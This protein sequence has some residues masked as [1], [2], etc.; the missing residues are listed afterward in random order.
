MELF[1]IVGAIIPSEMDVHK[2]KSEILAAL[3]M[4]K[5]NSLHP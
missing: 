2:R 5:A 4:T 3:M 1:R